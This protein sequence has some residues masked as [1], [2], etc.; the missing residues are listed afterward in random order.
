[1]NKTTIT[2]KMLSDG[3]VVEVLDDGHEIPFPD[4]PIRPMTD[5]EINAAAQ[6]DVDARPMTTDE[7]KTARRVPRV[8]TMRRALGIT[9]EEFA[10]WYHVPL[11]T[12]RDWEQGR[13][14]PDQPARAYL[15]VIA[16]D[17]EGVRRALQHSQPT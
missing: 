15:T 3:V 14:E 12:L 7:L 5:E 4:T 16:H 10:T 11:G 8:K 17:P 1:M 9:Q 6:A 13:T 2:A